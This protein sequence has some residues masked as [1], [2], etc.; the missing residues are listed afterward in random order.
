MD[1][2]KQTEEMILDLALQIVEAQT[3]I[4]DIQDISPGMVKL[5]EMRIDQLVA[6]IEA[7]DEAA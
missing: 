2:R 3:A 4:K 5:W 7:L 1:K 6:K